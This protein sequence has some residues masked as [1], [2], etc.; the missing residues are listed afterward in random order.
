M[1]VVA[2]IVVKATKK[3]K[4]TQRTRVNLKN[5]V[6]SKGKTTLTKIFGK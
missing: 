5:F 6:L 3:N 1:Y 2:A 4:Q